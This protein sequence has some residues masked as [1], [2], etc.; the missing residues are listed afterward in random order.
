MLTRLGQKLQ[1]VKW[2]EIR[3]A[4]VKEKFFTLGR[5]LKAYATGR[6]REVPWKTM[7][8]VTAS[9]IYFINPIDLFPDW[10]PGFGLTDDI[11]ILLS[12]YNAINQ[13][14]NKFLVWEQSQIAGENPD[15]TVL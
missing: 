8:L 7:L 1:H 14:V 15:P 12:V 2:K 13:E 5:L 9:I 10:I 4:D 3:T 11:G 6:Y